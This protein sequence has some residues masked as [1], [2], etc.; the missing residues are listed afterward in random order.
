MNYVT[1]L[2]FEQTPDYKMLKRWV[3]DAAK[4]VGVNIFDGQYDWTAKVVEMQSRKAA[5]KGAVEQ[6]GSSQNR[7]EQHSG[8]SSSQ[9]FDEPDY[10]DSF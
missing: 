9:N 4:S 8:S 10:F 7:L 5:E 2:D 1:S 6:S 3:L